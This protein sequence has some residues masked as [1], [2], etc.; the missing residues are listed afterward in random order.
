M[1]AF[2]ATET[3]IDLMDYPMKTLF[4]PMR[5]LSLILAVTLP[6]VSSAD[7]LKQIY[8]LAKTNNPE[9]RAANAALQS[10][11]Q[12][13]AI[14][15]ASLLPNVSLSARSR[16]SDDIG[17]SSGNSDT[18]NTYSASISQTLFNMSDWYSYQSGN[19]SVDRA[20]LNWE[21]EEQDLITNTVSAYL[22]VLRA[23]DTLTTVRAEKAALESQLEQTQQRFDV[24]L[25]PITDVLEAQASY[26]DVISR[27]LDGLGNLAIT[28]E[29]LRVLTGRQHNSIA[30]LMDNYPV[31]TPVPAQAE[32]WVAV[33]LENS[34]TLGIAEL[35]VE[36]AEIAKSNSNTNYYPAVELNASYGGSL[37]DND[38]AVM[39]IGRFDEG[40]AVSVTLTVPIVTFTGGSTWARRVQA[41]H[42]LTQAEE[43]LAGTQRNVE[44]TIRVTHLRV[45]TSIS[46]VQARL[47]AI[48]SSES[49]LEATQAGYE[50][51]TRN[52][53]DVLLAER[54][55][56]STTRN[57][58]NTRYDYIENMLNLKSTAGTLNG[59]DIDELNRWLDDA[60]E[61]PRSLLLP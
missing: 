16:Y 3:C 46:L 58:L 29:A 17:P 15:R 7:T 37:E 24:G 43:L 38:T 61:I 13:G 52:L 21:Q 33:G 50:V 55:L 32:D 47:Q 8:D 53:V 36:S 9:Y 42:N 20:L 27:E 48:R 30:P 49:A 12:N 2:W 4:R 5:N 6:C 45:L 40:G 60:N 28:Y 1:L 11:L 51:G 34:Q 25:V 18:S 59:Q 44:Q 22:D 10:D 39:P 26:D 23:I 56:Y 14:G 54:N 31:V 57:Y 41:R 19:I 35:S